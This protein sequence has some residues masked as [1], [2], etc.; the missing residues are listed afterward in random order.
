MERAR[1]W[2]DRQA[3][4]FHRQVSRMSDGD[5]TRFNA[6]AIDR[7]VREGWEWGR[8][9]SREGF[10]KAKQGEW[11]VLLT[12]NIPVPREWLGS[13]SGKKVLGLASGGAQQM[14]VFAALGAECTVFDLSD[15]QLDSERM[16]AAREG[17][18]I[19]I[20]KGDMTLPLPFPDGCF[21]LIFHPV[22][23][24]YIRDVRPVWREC[25]RVLAPGGVLLSGLDNGINF[26]FD[27]DG[28]RPV[29]RLPFDPLSDPDW[30]EK[31]TR[32]NDSLQF[33]HPIQDQVGGQLEAGFI[34]TDI[35]EDT[36]GEGL[37]KEL[38]APCF[39]ATRS[40]KPLH[41]IP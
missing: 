21:D 33:S 39:F 11:A 28:L 37:M 34:L 19:R 26:L 3:N 36:N 24:C 14:P 38:N 16:V 17:Y 23:N 35:Y 7:W 40:V 30:E 15:E 31:I 32:D 2:K 5:Y 13:L 9:I 1:E 20:I 27:D 22:S 12:P 6:Q 29:H 4:P 18:G 25:F 8:P 41:G 10:L